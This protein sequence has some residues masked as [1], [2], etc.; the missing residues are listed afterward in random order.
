V[1]ILQII[2]R[3]QPEVDK[4]WK[5]INHIPIFAMCSWNFHV[6]ATPGWLCWAPE[7]W[8]FQPGNQPGSRW[9]PFRTHEL[10]ISEKR[11]FNGLI[12]GFNSYTFW[13]TNSLSWTSPC[14]IGTVN[15]LWIETFF[16]AMLVYWRGSSQA[17]FLLWK[18]DLVVSEKQT[19]KMPDLMKWRLQE[20]KKKKNKENV[21]KRCSAALVLG[22][23]LKLIDV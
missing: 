5:T 3:N 11:F 14:L 13:Q 17:S 4:L 18:I 6:L 7:T 20:D 2:I 10:V 21:K 9:R 15:H 19:H 1:D 23:I 22:W 8:F 12:H 16:V